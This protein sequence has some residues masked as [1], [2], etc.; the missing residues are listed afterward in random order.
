MLHDDLAR[1][2]GLSTKATVTEQS[3]G[4]S[5][6]R[7]YHIADGGFEYYLK[8]APIAASTISLETEYRKTRWLGEFA[9]VAQLT[10]FV[11]R[12]GV[13]YFLSSAI[14]GKMS[15][16]FCDDPRGIITLIAESLR[17]LHTID[18]AKCPFDETLKVKLARA[19]EHVRN[20]S[21]DEDDFGPLTKGRSQSEVLLYLLQSDPGPD[22][23]VV[24]HGDYCMPNI[25]VAEEA[26]RVSGF[27]DLGS[28]GVSDRHYDLAVASRS[29]LRNYGAAFVPLFFD[30][31]GFEPDPKRIAYHQML[32]DLL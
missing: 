6:A 2:L 30:S 22:D 31:Y 15:Q 24:S 16:D 19:E 5:K 10:Q 28:L 29:I 27:V 14:E 25:I 32:E 20:H 3:V 4:C 8:T 12:D 21:I 26:S 11:V 7:T 23:L 17:R 1:E 18:I 13:E 9:P